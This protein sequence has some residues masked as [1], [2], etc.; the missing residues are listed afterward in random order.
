MRASPSL[1]RWGL[2]SEPYPDGFKAFAP[3]ASHV[4]A[5]SLYKPCAALYKGMNFIHVVQAGLV[6]AALLHARGT[7]ISVPISFLQ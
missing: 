4:K 1:G 5:V 7:S 2:V 6:L 3:L